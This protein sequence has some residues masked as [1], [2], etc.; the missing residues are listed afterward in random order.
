MNIAE[1]LAEF[2]KT[3][4]KPI[5]VRHRRSAKLYRLERDVVTAADPDDPFVYAWHVDH[6]P[7]RKVGYKW[8]NL[9]SLVPA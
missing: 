4:G 1:A 9:S 8:M 6:N 3:D 2:D 5:T 7:R